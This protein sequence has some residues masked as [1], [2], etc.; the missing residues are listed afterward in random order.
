MNRTELFIYRLGLILFSLGIIVGVIA[1]ILL[2]T[3]PIH[4]LIG[5]FVAFIAMMFVGFGA[6]FIIKRSTEDL[7]GF[8]AFILGATDGHIRTTPFKNPDDKSSKK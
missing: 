2:K 5:F 7:V 6:D 4:P 8:I 1:F 3:D